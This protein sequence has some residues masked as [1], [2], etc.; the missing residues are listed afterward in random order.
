MIK[1]EKK[2]EDTE[3]LALVEQLVKQYPFYGYGKIT[4]ILHYQ[5][6]LAINRKRV[7]RIMKENKLV[8]PPSCTWGVRGRSCRNSHERRASFG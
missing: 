3:V 8:M 6:G 4:A 2:K 1:E 7:Y 5:R